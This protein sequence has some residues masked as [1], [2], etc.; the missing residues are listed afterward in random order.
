MK[1]KTMSMTRRRIIREERDIAMVHRQ[2]AP[3]VLV[4]FG[5][6][7]NRLSQR[8]WPYPGQASEWSETSAELNAVSA[9][10][11]R[12]EAAS[13]ITWPVSVHMFGIDKQVS[14]AKGR[15]NLFIHILQ[16]AVKAVVWS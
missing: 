6:E 10:G 2:S 12:E 11:T 3:L 1:K 9:V 4:R 16:Q 7:K 8:V 14:V 5:S 13:G 15:E